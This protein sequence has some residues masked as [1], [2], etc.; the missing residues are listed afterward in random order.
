MTPGALGRKA[1]RPLGRTQGGALMTRGEAYAA[2]RT[3]AARIEGQRELVHLLA[4]SERVFPANDEH[5]QWF[6]DQL[7]DELAYL[8]ELEW[9]LGELESFASGLEEDD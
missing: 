4:E 8:A 1:V 2:I 9:G 3:E 7:T 6:T 5:R